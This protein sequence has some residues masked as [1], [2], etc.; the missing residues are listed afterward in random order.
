ML[1]I[2]SLTVFVHI[3]YPG[4]ADVSPLFQDLLS[5]YL[6]LVAQYENL[7]AMYFFLIYSIS[8]FGQ[9]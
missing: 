2:F 4:L 3:V 6:Y 5:V 8:K 7:G 9:H 1:K